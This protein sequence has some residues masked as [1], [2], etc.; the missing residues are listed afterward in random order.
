MDVSE[1]SMARVTEDF[2]KY[3]ETIKKSLAKVTE[4]D[5]VASA[6]REDLRLVADF[7]MVASKLIFLK[8]KYLLP[9][10]ALTEEEEADIKDLEDRLKIYQELKPALRIV[11]K[12]WRESHRSYSRPYFL[13]HGGG[14]AAGQKVFYPGGNVTVAR[15][16]GIAR[17]GYSKRSRPMSSKRRPSRKRSSRLRKRSLRFLRASNGKGISISRAGDEDAPRADI[18]LIFLGRAASCPR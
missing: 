13:G 16:R 11:A 14:L 10:L 3:L 5:G 2:L 15:A 8:S 17:T 9:G 4:C 12:L 7:I 6:F 1:V 18:I